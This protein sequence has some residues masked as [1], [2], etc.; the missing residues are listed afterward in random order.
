MA[1]IKNSFSS[2]SK[3]VLA[4]PDWNPKE[5]SDQWNGTLV[6]DRPKKVLDKES[7]FH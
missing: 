2:V 1:N 7:G 5:I 3:T 4:V 6:D